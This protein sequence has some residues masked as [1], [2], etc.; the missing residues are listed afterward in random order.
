MAAA[1]LAL[2]PILSALPVEVE[3]RVV[4]LPALAIADLELGPEG[5]AALVDTVAEGEA[6]ETADL[7]ER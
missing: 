3:D 5:G 2:P 7:V 4:L 6:A 1:E